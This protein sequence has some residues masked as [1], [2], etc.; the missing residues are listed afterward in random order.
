MPGP[1]G[2]LPDGAV[3]VAAGQAYTVAHGWPFRWTEQGYQAARQKSL[4][5]MAC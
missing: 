2:E 5:P 3:I 1:V 4:T